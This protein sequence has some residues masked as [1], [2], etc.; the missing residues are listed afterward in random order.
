MS[1]TQLDKIDVMGF[2]EASD[3]VVLTISDH[4]DWENPKEH[5]LILQE[6]INGYVRFVEHKE[7]LKSKPEYAG[8]SVRIK[9]ACKYDFP[10]IGIEFIEAVAEIVSPLIGEIVLQQ[11]ALD[12]KFWVSE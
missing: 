7:Y 8:K 11:L 10:P 1:I 4:F 9:I 12:D 2:D 6:K 5:L 3:V